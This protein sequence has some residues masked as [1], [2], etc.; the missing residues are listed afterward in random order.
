MIDD[1]STGKEPTSV[2]LTAH[3]NFLNRRKYFLH[4]IDGDLTSRSKEPELPH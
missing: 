1:A 3:K 4:G 2:T